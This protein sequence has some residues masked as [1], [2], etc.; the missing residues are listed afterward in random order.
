MREN[1]IG[2]EPCRAIGRAVLALQFMFADTP[3]GVTN[4][5]EA[6]RD[7]WTHPPATGA[8]PVTLAGERARRS[9]RPR[10]AS[11]VAA[12]ESAAVTRHLL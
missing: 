6:P 5:H 12:A 2:I 8:D 4:G 11:L 10:R 9:D 7:S 1:L 3:H